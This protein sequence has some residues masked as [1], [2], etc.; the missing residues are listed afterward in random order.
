MNSGE[1]NKVH[2]QELLRTWQTG[3]LSKVDSLVAQDYI[4]HVSAGDRD[5]K[6]LK[7]RIAEFKTRFPDVAFRVDDQLA[8]GEKLVTRMT[9]RATDTATGREIVMMGINISRFSDGHLCEEWATWEVLSA[10]ES[11]A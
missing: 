4:G 3:D 1:E 11:T 8:V 10:L 5:I 6:G 9:A 7:A 2:F